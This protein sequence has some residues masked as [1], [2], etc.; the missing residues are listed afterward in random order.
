[1]LGGSVLVI[2]FTFFFGTVNFRAHLAMTMIPGASIGLVLFL[3]VAMGYPFH[4]GTSIHPDAFGRAREDLKRVTGEYAP[5]GHRP[6]TRASE[7][8]IHHI[9]EHPSCG[10]GDDPV[11]GGRGG[12]RVRGA[13]PSGA[14]DL[15]ALRRRLG[16][17]RLDG[18]A[19][20]DPRGH[21]AARLGAAQSPRGGPPSRSD[22]ALPGRAPPRTEGVPA[23]PPRAD[24]ARARRDG[25]RQGRANPSGGPP[26]LGDHAAAIHR[27]PG[28]PNL[29]GPVFCHEAGRVRRP[30]PRVRCRAATPA[31]PPARLRARLGMDGILQ[32]LDRIA[33][34][35]YAS[36]GGAVAWER[37]NTEWVPVPGARGGNQ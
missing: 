31:A 11:R 18:H 23:C 2:A 17:A 37:T 24:A 26:H 1:M 30:G 25:H 15:E 33:Y 29:G 32:P 16:R 28:G 9:R 12:L 10:P 8:R 7:M 36:Y 20:R 3:I 21:A 19:A 6:L 14:G 27:R 35:A 22:V 13:S 4:G 34:D 5:D